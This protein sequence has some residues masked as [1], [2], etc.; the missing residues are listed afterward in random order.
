MTGGHGDLSDSVPRQD[1]GLAEP[2]IN[3][4]PDSGNILLAGQTVN[5]QLTDNCNSKTLATFDLNDSTDVTF[6]FK[7]NVLLWRALLSVGAPSVS[8][9]QSVEG[10]GIT[11]MKGLTLSLDALGSHYYT[12]WLDGEIVD[13]GKTCQYQSLLLGTFS[14]SPAMKRALRTIRLV[15]MGMSPLEPVL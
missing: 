5:M 15:R 1:G 8:L 10:C 6:Y 9:I 7:N 11:L 3:D 4:S 2:R 12:V 14:R 13:A